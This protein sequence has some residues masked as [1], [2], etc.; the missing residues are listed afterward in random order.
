LTIYYKR[1]KIKVALYDKP[2]DDDEVEDNR[3]YRLP[4]ALCKAR[5]IAVPDGATP[6][7]AWMLLKGYGVNP[8]EE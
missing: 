7:D 4:F 2:L 1:G 3:K 5:G 6:R 8:D